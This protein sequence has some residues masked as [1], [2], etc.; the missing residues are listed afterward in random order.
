L[1][2][3][4]AT[5]DYMARRLKQG[6]SK[7]EIIRCLKRY[8]AREVFAVLNQMGQGSP[9]QPLDIYTSV[10]PRDNLRMAIRTRF[11]EGVRDALRVGSLW[12]YR[13]KQTSRSAAW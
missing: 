6:K 2:Y 8:V 1:C 4:P 7:K 10:G 9:P 12:S 3:D 5:K 11:I 13:P